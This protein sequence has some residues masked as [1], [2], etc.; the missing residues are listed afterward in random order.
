[1][2]KREA[3]HRLAEINE[4]IYD[5]ENS[6][7]NIESRL[8]WDNEHNREWYLA[9]KEDV[10]QKLENAKEEHDTFISEYSDIIYS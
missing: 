5:L 4:E 2:D 6:L 3:C 9:R 10:L 7:A 1:M 8:G